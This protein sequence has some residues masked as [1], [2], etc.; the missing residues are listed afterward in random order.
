MSKHQGRNHK[1]VSH[2]E[3]EIPDDEIIH[4]RPTGEDGRKE[5]KDDEKKK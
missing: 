5:K 4:V 3:L 1:V 2:A